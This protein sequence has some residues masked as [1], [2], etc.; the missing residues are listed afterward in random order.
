M[1]KTRGGGGKGHLN[2]VKKTL[3]YWLMMASLITK[4]TEQPTCWR[5]PQPSVPSPPN[6]PSPPSRELLCFHL[7][8]LIMKGFLKSMIMDM[9]PMM[10]LV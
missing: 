5:H 10:I 8:L 3:H 1:F 9:M 4:D 6:R 2:N 7:V